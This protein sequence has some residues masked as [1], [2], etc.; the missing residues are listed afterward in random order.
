MRPIIRQINISC[1]F[2]T[3]S[4]IF[5]ERNFRDISEYSRKIQKFEKLYQKILINVR[6]TRKKVKMREIL[7]SEVEV[8]ENYCW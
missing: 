2:P 3:S 7:K 8:H 1:H 5:N 6:R 4:A